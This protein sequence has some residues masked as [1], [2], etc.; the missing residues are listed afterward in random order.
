[1]RHAERA[2]PKTIDQIESAGLEVDLVLIP[3]GIED[4]VASF[5]VSKR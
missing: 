3:T 5:V 1:M 2:K 4:A